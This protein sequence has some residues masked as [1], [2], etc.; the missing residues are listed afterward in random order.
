MIKGQ[1]W[2]FD[3]IFA[4][5]I[6]SFTIT[7]LAVTWYNLNNNLSISNGNG[8]NIM[9]LQLQTLTLNL[10][11]QGSPTN[12]QS[13]V[14]TTNSSTWN[15]ISVGLGANPSGGVLSVNKVYTLASMANSNYQATKQLLGV[16]FDYYITIKSSNNVTNGINMSIGSNPS[17]NGALTVYV[18]H[19][20]AIM[21]GEPVSVEIDLW[22]NTTL[23][24]S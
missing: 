17:K 2:S 21:G 10:F 12:W 16:G 15:Y 3:V 23:A 18:S 7:V 8:S 11:T 5:I 14:N 13:A 9:Q 24:T 20:N 1:F 6:F 19:T 22:T 4:I